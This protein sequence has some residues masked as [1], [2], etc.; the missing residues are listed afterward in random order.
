MV[1]RQQ[2]MSEPIPPFYIRTL[3]SLET[4]LNSALAKEKEAKK[5]MNASNARALTAM[6]QKVKKTAKEYEKELKQ[7][8]EVR[9]SVTC[10]PA[11]SVLDYNQDPEAYERQYTVS[12]APPVDSAAP[13][14][15]KNKAVVDVEEDGDFETVGKGG[16]S[17]Q[18][19]AEGI[20]K[21]LQMI[22]EARGKKVFLFLDPR[23]F[24]ALLISCRIQTVPINYAYLKNCSKSQKRR[25]SG[26][27]FSSVLSLPG[28]TTTRQ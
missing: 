3:S 21:N 13:K 7:F 9:R 18:F 2:N 19:T 1:Q 20:F 8:Q 5:K 22:Q 23:V 4:S 27:V 14:A 26:Y 11:P 6:K 25:T 24:I 12:S 28:S 15:K 10:T 17:I 16:K